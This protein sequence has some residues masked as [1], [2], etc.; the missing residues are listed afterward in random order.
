[1]ESKKDDL[2]NLNVSGDHITARRSTLCLY[3]G[4]YLASMFSGRWEN[5]VT[6]DSSGRVFLELNPQ[7]FRKILDF[8]IS[9][10]REDP[11]SPTLPPSVQEHMVGEL[12]EA[13]KY[14]G[15]EDIWHQNAP[16]LQVPLP[17]SV[18]LPPFWVHVSSSCAQLSHG[19]SIMTYKSARG[20]RIYV[21]SCRPLEGQCAW[22]FV[23]NSQ[24]WTMVGIAGTDEVHSAV[25]KKVTGVQWYEMGYLWPCCMDIFETSNSK[26]TA[27]SER[28][29][30]WMVF[31]GHNRTL[32]VYVPV[33]HYAKLFSLGPG[34]WYL[35]GEVCGVG[36]L[37]L[38]PLQSHEY[39]TVVQT[40]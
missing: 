10:S 18:A 21:S 11:I 38:Q 36:R 31:D 34:P 3:E 20:S 9:K 30:V 23:S 24:D 7:I 8:L 2:V 12:D 16:C 15:L 37:C 26:A 19:G 17:T 27:F 1:M 22:K 6:K 39:S 5:A 29:E 28:K 25:A 14:L 32:A 35:H 33:V 40:V 4:T 13:L